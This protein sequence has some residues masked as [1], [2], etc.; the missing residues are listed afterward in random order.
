MSLYA[1]QVH[2]PAPTRQPRQPVSRVNVCRCPSLNPP[3]HH[4]TFALILMSVARFPVTGAAR[5]DELHL[6]PED[7]R[8]GAMVLVETPAGGIGCEAGWSSCLQPL[9]L[10]ETPVESGPLPRLRLE[11]L[12]AWTRKFSPPLARQAV[13]T[14]THPQPSVRGPQRSTRYQVAQGTGEARRGNFGCGSPRGPRRRRGRPANSWQRGIVRGMSYGGGTMGTDGKLDQNAGQDGTVP[15]GG[16]GAWIVAGALVAYRGLVAHRAPVV[17]RVLRIHPSPTEKCLW[18]ATP[19]TAT[20]RIAGQPGGGE[21]GSPDASEGPEG[22]TNTPNPDDPPPPT[23]SLPRSCFEIAED[24]A[25]DDPPPKSG[26][27]RSTLDAEPAR[28]LPEVFSATS[29]PHPRVCGVDT[30][31]CAVHWKAGKRLVRHQPKGVLSQPCGEPPIQRRPAREFAL[32]YHQRN[33]GISTR[34]RLRI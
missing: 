17:R 24:T 8:P 9:G 32:L 28:G 13:L 6:A 34:R 29:T 10:W 20:P 19:T 26:Y 27:I 25:A 7:A 3:A 22:G 1:T 23:T 2:R 4:L 16:M 5:Y 21:G 15:L 11:R 33:R 18:G 30:P 12:R 14:T 31:V